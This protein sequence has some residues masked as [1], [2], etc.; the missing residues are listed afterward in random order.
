MDDIPA[1]DVANDDTNPL[2]AA[3]ERASPDSAF[4]DSV[5]PRGTGEVGNTS[6]SATNGEPQG[7]HGGDDST[8]AWGQESEVHHYHHQHCPNQECSAEHHTP[9]SI[10]QLNVDIQGLRTDINQAF[11]TQGLVLR[12]FENVVG[13]F[14]SAL[15]SF[16][17]NAGASGCHNCTGPPPPRG[18]RP[19]NSSPRRRAQQRG[20]WTDWEPVE[21]RSPVRGRNAARPRSSPPS[22]QRAASSLSARIAP[23]SI[24]GPSRRPSSP[25]PQ[26]HQ[27]SPPPRSPIPTP[28]VRTPV[29]LSPTSPSRLGSH[30]RSANPRVTEHNRRSTRNYL[31]GHLVRTRELNPN[32]H[33][34]GGWR[35]F[36]IRVN[37]AGIYETE[38]EVKRAWHTAFEQ[39]AHGHFGSLW[40]RS[41]EDLR[42]ALSDAE[43]VSPLDLI[44]F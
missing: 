14:T 31:F 8:D 36:V 6:D 26:Q 4:A 10:A 13:A 29:R 21:V 12:T 37:R 17:E 1:R 35:R 44:L 7:A 28:R 9:Q 33:R 18:R 42:A 5:S 2:P 23:L 38:E 30:L 22:P 39:Y 27:G 41:L 40:N 34:E 43:S 24:Q 3:E 11:Y 19:S 15:N 25:P 16:R 32:V 20:G